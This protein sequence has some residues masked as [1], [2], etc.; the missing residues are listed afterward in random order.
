MAVSTQD[1]SSVLAL[2]RPDSDRSWRIQAACRDM[3]AERFFPAGTR[4]IADEVAAA[5][6]ICAVCPVRDPCLEFAISTKQ[7]F[8]VW[9]GTDEVQRRRMATRRLLLR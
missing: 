7:E 2:P 3:P 9:G 4:A 1:R 5:K 8:G 6:A